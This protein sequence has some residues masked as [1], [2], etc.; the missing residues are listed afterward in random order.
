VFVWRFSEN[1]ILFQTF[2]LIPSQRPAIIIGPASYFLI[3]HQKFISSRRII[4]LLAFKYMTKDYDK[5]A[6][7]IR[8][9][10]LS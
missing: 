6:L 10:R 9:E 1:I 2:S 8:V 4:R 3:I 5:K 7:N